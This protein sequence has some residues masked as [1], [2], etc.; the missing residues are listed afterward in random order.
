MEGDSSFLIVTGF[1]LYMFK[2]NFKGISYVKWNYPPKRQSDLIGDRKKIKEISYVKLK[3]S[4]EKVGHGIY[5]SR[6]IMVWTL[7]F[8][9]VIRETW[10]S[11]FFWSLLT[12]RNLFWCSKSWTLFPIE[13][14]TSATSRLLDIRS[15][16]YL[17]MSARVFRS[18]CSL[19]SKVFYLSPKLSPFFTF[20]IAK[21]S[22]HVGARISFLVTIDHV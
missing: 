4:Y 20:S 8:H 7:Q 18:S 16:W 19:Q 10:A 22:C 6:R 13:C 3:A 11:C 5:I 14:C 9:L 17:S 1:W 15:F 21:I 2:I 12:I